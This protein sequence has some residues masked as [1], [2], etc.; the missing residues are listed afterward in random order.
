MEKE[1]SK[2]AL[3]HAAT[4]EKYSH[5]PGSTPAEKRENVRAEMRAK[6]EE[7][8]NSLRPSARP[9]ESPVRASSTEMAQPLSR[10][11]V[12]EHVTPPA[13]VNPP[14]AESFPHQPEEPYPKPQDH[15]VQTIH[16]SALTVSHTEPPPGSVH[17]GSSEFAIP[18]PMDSRVKDDYEG[19]LRREARIIRDFMKGFEPNSK[20]SEAEVSKTFS[21]PLF[22]ELTFE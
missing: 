12:K 21:D 13:A 11:A 20:L 3:S 6:I 22:W 8:R 18:L 2:Q 17:L 1:S 14:V 5:V 10:G 9:S 15:P 19:V 4:M 7:T 16:P